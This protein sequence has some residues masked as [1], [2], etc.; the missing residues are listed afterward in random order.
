MS[1]AR[2][3]LA[4]LGVALLAG[5]VAAGAPGALDGEPRGS[6]VAADNTTG[7]LQ[8]AADGGARRGYVHQDV[9]VGVAVAGDVA[10]LEARHQ[11][12]AFERAVADAGSRS[13]RLAAIREHVTALEEGTA[14]IQA[15]GREARRGYLEGSLSTEA[16]VAR[17][18]RLDA[19]AAALETLRHTVERR[20]A[21]LNPQPQ[22]ALTDVQNLE[23]AL[24]TIGGPATRRSRE[25]FGGNRSAGA[26]Y[27]S[28]TGADGL[29][30][31]TVADGS[32]YREALDL[33]E[34]NPDGPDRFGGSDEPE[35]SVA[36]R[37]ASVLYPWAFEHGSAAQPIRGYGD[38]AVYRITVQHT[39]GQLS[40]YLDGATENVF[41]EIQ[42]KRL[43][44]VPMP[45]RER[46]VADGL[47]LRVNATHGSGPLEVSV[48]RTDSSIPVDAAIAVDGV[49]V[50]RTGD[51][52]RLWTV[53]SAGT[54]TVS[55]RTADNA[56]VQVSVG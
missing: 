46:A 32:L 3:A 56:T 35:I 27:V 29:V 24:Q 45:T 40:V 48:G 55:A 42:R 9:D 30:V 52:G 14:A 21:S 43:S 8:P 23:A 25:R 7:Y 34:R 28:V 19:R 26:T 31:A 39:Q 47:E 4:L 13:E 1:L 51:D 17:L 33:T 15:A 36:L 41:R 20:T 44:A 50:G 6:I 10:A 12:L 18:A 22:A 2:I 11:R 38:T 5:A 49:R 16:F 54:T 53:Q 37:R